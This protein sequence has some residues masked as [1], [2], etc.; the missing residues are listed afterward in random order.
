MIKAYKYCTLAP[1]ACAG[2]VDTAAFSVPTEPAAPLKQ[3]SAA[4]PLS[5]GAAQHGITPQAALR[6]L[7]ASQQPPPH[8]LS[9]APAG[10]PHQPGQVSELQGQ[11]PMQGLDAPCSTP[12]PAL[13]KE[14]PLPEQARGLTAG[15]QARM[16]NGPAHAAHAASPQPSP[17]PAATWTL[18]TAQQPMQPMLPAVGGA[19]AEL[20][21]ATSPSSEPKHSLHAL[22]PMTGG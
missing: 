7:S 13:P 5:V 21:A 16:A 8:T 11:Q 6:T 19:D 12:V 15:K 14:T 17:T 2:Q 1:Y 22:K 4:T 20:P 10:T 9:A 3:L 18:P